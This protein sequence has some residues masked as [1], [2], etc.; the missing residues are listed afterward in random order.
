MSR[1]TVELAMIVRN[2]GAGLARCLKS[3]LPAVNGIV[4]GDTGSTDASIR[5][6]GA[7]GA[8]VLCVGWENDFSKARNTVLAACT[9]DWVLS[10]DA[11]EMLDPEGAE[12]IPALIAQEKIDAWEVWRWNYV[13]T[14]NSRSGDR[15]AQ[16]N[17]MRLEESRCYPAFTRG[18]NTLLFRRYPGVYFENPV[19]ETV[20]KRIR[21]LGLTAAE[22]PFVIHHFGFVEDSEAARKAKCELYQQLGWQKLRENPRDYWAIYELGLGE[23]EHYRDPVAALALFEQALALKPELPGARIYAGICLTRLGRFPEAFVQLQRAAQIAPISVLLAESIGDVYFHSGAV[24]QALR[25]YEQAAQIATVSA[26]VECK[27]GGCLVSLGDCAAGL[28]RIEAT[29]AREPD[30]GEL[31]EIWAAAALLAGETRQAARVAR[32]RLLFG[33]PPAVSYIVAAGLEA[34]QG[35]W[36]EALTILRDGLERYPGNPV[37]EK[38]LRVARERAGVGAAEQFVALGKE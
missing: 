19:H 5:V 24:A 37:L 30:A 13:R 32:Q 26:L 34:R 36:N 6:A 18:L 28:A 2:G 35:C 22:A 25:C 11:D 7:F 21:A 4:V 14:L 33:D 29:V 10:L 1:P 31:Y 20:S 38:E 8:R 3:A 15:A 16:P 17:P 23:L 27:R 12:Q 9:A